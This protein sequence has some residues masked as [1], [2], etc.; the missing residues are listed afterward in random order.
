MGAETGQIL[1]EISED[2]VN[3]GRPMLS[4]VAVGVN[5]KPGSGFFELAKRMGRLN[6]VA[7]EVT[8]WKAER[9]AVYQV[10]RRPLPS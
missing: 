10:W 1:G 6:H 7:D 8:F 5:G 3:A 4:S 2:E 9:E